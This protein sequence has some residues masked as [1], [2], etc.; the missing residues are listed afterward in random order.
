MKFFNGY[1][2]LKMKVCKIKEQEMKNNNIS[3]SD[4]FNLK[5]QFLF[6]INQLWKK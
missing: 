6:Q 4:I 2:N 1:S 3:Y 5:V